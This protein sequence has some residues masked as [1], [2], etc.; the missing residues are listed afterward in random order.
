[1]SVEKIGMREF[2]QITHKV[3]KRLQS[4]K[5]GY[6][7]DGGREIKINSCMSSAPMH[8]MGFYFLPEGFHQKLDTLRSD[9]Y[10]QGVGDKKKKY[11]LI[12]RDA[13]CRPKEY[14]GMGF[15]N[16][17]IM[18]ICLLSKWIWKL[19]NGDS[20][21]C[22]EVQRKKYL[23]DDSFFNSSEAGGSQFWKG[24]H[25]CKKW[26]FNL[27][28]NEV[29][30]GQKANFWKDVWLGD[31]FLRIRFPELYEISYDQNTSVKDMC[32]LG[33]WRLNFRRNLDEQRKRYV[34]EL[35]EPFIWI[36]GGIDCYGLLMKSLYY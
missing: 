23:G 36:R 27:V 2:C 11:H 13:L 4:W 31:T 29:H 22:L 17:R 28:I 16:T 15:L 21:M 26:L 6:L 34:R 3:E 9:F 30:C 5:S 14:G 19:D 7:T 24:L 1:M 25:K 20:D 32:D 33:V 12:K 10:W 18:N 8:A 35:G